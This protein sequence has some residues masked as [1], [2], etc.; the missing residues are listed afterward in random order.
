[1]SIRVG[2][3]FIWI[4]SSELLQENK[5]LITLLDKLEIHSIYFYLRW[6]K[7]DSY[8][9]VGSQGLKAVAKVNFSFYCL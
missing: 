9:P 5:L 3:V 7:R 1:M 8:L 4:V 6:V 2:L